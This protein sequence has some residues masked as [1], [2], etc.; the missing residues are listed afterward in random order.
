MSHLSSEMMTRIH[1][2]TKN[3]DA[4]YLTIL[5]LDDKIVKN[6]LFEITKT[7]YKLSENS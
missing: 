5:T 6:R 1:Y 3:G 2:S 4:E 7:S